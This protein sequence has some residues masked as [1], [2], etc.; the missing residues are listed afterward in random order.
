[1]GE[2]GRRRAEGFVLELR[3]AM[4]DMIAEAAGFSS[5]ETAQPANQSNGRTPDFS[6]IN[7]V[8]L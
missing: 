1:M 2:R 7:T 3:F 5:G 8:V 6:R 4:G